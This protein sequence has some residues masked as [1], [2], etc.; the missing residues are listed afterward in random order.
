MLEYE[1]KLHLDEHWEKL[2]K[3]QIGKICLNVII[4]MVSYTIL[5]LGITWGLTFISDVSAWSS[6]SVWRTIFG[7]SFLNAD[8]VYFIVGI[9]FYIYASIRFFGINEQNHS[10]R[11]KEDTPNSL[12]T[13]G[14]YAKVRHP[15]YGVFIM[16]CAFVLLSVRSLIG[17][18]ICVL[19][20]VS[21]Y[22][23][24]CREEKKVLIPLFA[25]AY[26][27][28][29]KQVTQ[30]L[31]TKVQVIVISIMIIINIIGFLI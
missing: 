15:M 1:K 22:L 2:Q 25:D 11:G 13:T 18:V 4:S 8:I 9:L 7:L 24:A 20:A 28:Y 16:R 3:C 27:N 29:S 5:F 14:Y 12:L 10:V 30:L 23:N 6:S 19:F 21:Q 17:I 26:I 31:L